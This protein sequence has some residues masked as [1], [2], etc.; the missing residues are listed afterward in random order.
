MGRREAERLS[1]DAGLQLGLV[2]G[3]LSAMGGVHGGEGGEGG[4]AG[5]PWA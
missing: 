2:V 4:K 5:A 3:M 1:R